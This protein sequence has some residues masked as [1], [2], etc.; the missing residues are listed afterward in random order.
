MAKQQYNLPICRYINYEL[1]T[2]VHK[3]QFFG[4]HRAA[5]S[6]AAVRHQREFLTAQQERLAVTAEDCVSLLH[7][8]GGENT[9]VEKPSRP[10][11]CKGQEAA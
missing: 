8:C 10:I 5:A 1:C 3:R 7:S 11:G 6:V 2:G 4:L 9:V